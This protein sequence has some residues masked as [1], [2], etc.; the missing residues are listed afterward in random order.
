MAPMDDGS[1]P[2]SALFDRSRSVRVCRFVM[3]GERAPDSWFRRIDSDA[4]DA[5]AVMVDGSDPLSWLLDA[6]NVFRLC[7]D[8]MDV[9][10]VPEKALSFSSSCL[11]NR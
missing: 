3:P 9:G 7:S 8:L 1:C 10:R 2:V 11:S 5:S 6:V 4:S